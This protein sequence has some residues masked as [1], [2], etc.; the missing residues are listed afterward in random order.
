MFAQA[1]IGL[2]ITDR[3]GMIC[4]VNDARTGLVVA[5]QR[6]LFSPDGKP[7]A[8]RDVEVIGNGYDGASAAARASWS[9]SA[10]SA[11]ARAT[12]RANSRACS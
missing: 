7:L 5:L 9:A 12:M 10:P 11:T 4:A 8:G 1:A 2:L 3:Q 6:T